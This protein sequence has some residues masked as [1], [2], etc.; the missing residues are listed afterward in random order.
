M[1]EIASSVIFRRQFLVTVMPRLLFGGYSIRIPVLL[2]AILSVFVLLF[3]HYRQILTH[4]LLMIIFAS[5]SVL[6]N[7]CSKV[8]LEKPKVVHM[9][10]NFTALY[11]TI[12]LRA[13]RPRFD[14][15]QGRKFCLRHRVQTGSGVYPAFCLMGTGALLLLVSRLRMRGAIPPLFN[16]S[17][18]CRT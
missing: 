18:W 8:L 11:G 1:K 14:S 2:P 13:G 15:Q 16:T 6:Y 9:V 7:L 10:K 17:S 12:R 3:S 4:S 5:Y